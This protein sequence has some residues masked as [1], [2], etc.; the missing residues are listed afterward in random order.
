MARASSVESVLTEKDFDRVWDYLEIKFSYSKLWRSQCYEYVLN[1]K[2]L[3][4]FY[5]PTPVADFLFF[6]VLE[7]DPLLNAA[8]C[9]NEYHPTF[10]QMLFWMFKDRIEKKIRMFRPLRF[11][12][13]NI[14]AV[15]D[16][17][18]DVGVDFLATWLP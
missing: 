9:W 11:F 1:R 5:K 18:V 16:F 4:V 6:G 17:N 8:L 12:L 2:P 14:L 7:L 3:F 10:M 13:L 15:L